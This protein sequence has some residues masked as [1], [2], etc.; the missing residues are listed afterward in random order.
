M[1]GLQ[2]IA[3]ASTNYGIGPAQSIIENSG[4]T[5][6]LRCSASEGGGNESGGAQ[7]RGVDRVPRSS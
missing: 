5:L 6:I 1:I 7:S 3:Q 4:N 2:S